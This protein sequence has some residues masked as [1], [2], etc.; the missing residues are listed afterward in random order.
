M[1]CQ[2]LLSSY[3]REHISEVTSSIIFERFDQRQ[4]LK[5]SVTTWFI[6]A[7]KIRDC[8]FPLCFDAFTTLWRVLMGGQK[9]CPN[10]NQTAV[11]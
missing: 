1:R 5:Q 3:G 4:E 7:R 2:V 8:Q 10:K 9:C 11:G 6:D